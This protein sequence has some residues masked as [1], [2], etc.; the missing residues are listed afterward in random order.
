VS[1][2]TIVLANGQ[3]ITTKE[4][5]FKDARA[6]VRSTTGPFVQITDEQGTTHFLNPM[7]IV[8]VRSK[9]QDPTRGSI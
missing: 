1:R 9:M 4:L 5:S 2:W 6:L 3:E 7:H 8:A